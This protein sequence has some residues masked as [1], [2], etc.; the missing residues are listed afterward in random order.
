MDD[1]ELVDAAKAGDR[2]AF[3]TRRALDLTQDDLARQ[4]GCSVVTIRKI[5]ADERRPSRQIAERLADCLMIAADERARIITLARGEPYLDPAPVEAPER[6]LRAPQRPPTNLPAPLT[7]LI[8]RKQDIAA[9]RN[10]LLRGETRLLTLVGP[11]GI[12]KTRLSIAVA[13]DVQAA[14]ADGAYF[15]ALAPIG[16]PALV[17]AT[18]AQTLGVRETAGQPLLEQLKSRASSADGCCWCWITSSR[19]WMPRRWWWSC[20][21]RVQG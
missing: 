15:V 10:A 4:V 11:P 13:H 17:L 19:C 1:R 16:D 20:W 3:R 9:V 5:E 18:I 12:G 6:P 2:D 14:F 8:G 21:R 7:R